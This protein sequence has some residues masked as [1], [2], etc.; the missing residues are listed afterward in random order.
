M[1][2]C[3]ITTKHYSKHASMKRSFGMAPVLRHLG[4]E[5]TLVLLDHPDNHGLAAKLDNGVE[6]VF[7]PVS[8]MLA[9]RRWKR[10]FLDGRSF[11][12]IIYNSLCWRNAVRKP[13][14]AMK[15]LALMEHCELE[16]SFKHTSL[17]RRTMQGILE[18]WVLWAFEGHICSSRY[19]FS[20]FKRRMFFCGIQRKIVWSP[21]G[22]DDE[23]CV[24][25]EI[26]ALKRH[27]TSHFEILHI[28]SLAKGYGC[29][30]MIQG[31]RELL[32]L[33][34]DW[35][36]CFVGGGPDYA[37]VTSA[38]RSLGLEDHVTFTGYAPEE[39]LR[40]KL[41]GAD[42]YL[43]HLNDTEKDWARCPSKLYYYMAQGKPVVT[44]ALGENHVALGGDGFYYQHDNPSDFARALSAA[45]DAAN[46]WMPRYDPTSV[47]WGCRTRQLLDEIK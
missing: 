14:R 38:A 25:S 12:V 37:E 6:S 22:V 27:A 41:A 21:Y 1:K 30:F 34:A 39:I 10:K 18:W 40:E 19:L 46:S 23:L 7:F 2:F 5:V 33:R 42:V 43:S 20:L 31:L 35:S 16:S 17:L 44:P 3:F 8:G 32:A 45:M 26:L 47:G 11:D 15:T 36:M 9:E 28:G 24:P 29:M 4:H 13:S